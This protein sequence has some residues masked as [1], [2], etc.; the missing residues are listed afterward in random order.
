MR[1]C[2]RLACATESLEPRAPM[3]TGGCEGVGKGLA[4]SFD[5]MGSRLLHARPRSRNASLAARGR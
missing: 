2:I 1:R 3:R 4:A 5:Q